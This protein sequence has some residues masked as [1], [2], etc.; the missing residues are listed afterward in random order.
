MDPEVQVERFKLGTLTVSGVLLQ[1]IPYC[2]RRG[3]AV[4]LQVKVLVVGEG[5]VDQSSQA[6]VGEGEV[7]QSGTCMYRKRGHGWT[8]KT[9]WE[10]K[11]G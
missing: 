9:I 7:D 6:V 10:N 1:Q 5:D 8:G 4:Q 11:E 2:H 3:R